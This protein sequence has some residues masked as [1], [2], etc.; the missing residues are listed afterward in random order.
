[1]PVSPPLAGPAAAVAYLLAVARAAGVRLSRAKLA[2]LLYLVDLRAAEEGI[3]CGSGV[4]WRASRQGPCSRALAEVEH[5]LSEAGVIQ[6]EDRA[7]PFTG[8]TEGVVHLIDAPQMVIDT[9]LSEVVDAVL[10]EHGRW[11]AGQ[12]HEFALQTAP[13]REAIT[14]G[15][16]DA[17]LDLSGGP[18]LPD[19]GTGL[20]RLR[21][22]ARHNPLP[23]DEPGSVDGLVEESRQLTEHRA[24]ATRHL[25]EE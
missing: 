17:R 7:D 5:G 6:V 4:E 18:P 2:G 20:D 19:L 9:A 21:A 15:L 24:E 1:M 13:M 11:S 14:R 23:E 25:L 8:C 16:P 10:A 3:L 22:W 12:L